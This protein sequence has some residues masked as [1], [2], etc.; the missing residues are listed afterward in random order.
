MT[1][2]ATVPNRAYFRERLFFG[3]AENDLSKKFA[4][5]SI[6]QEADQ[7]SISSMWRGLLGSRAIE[8][9]NKYR[10]ENRIDN[11]SR[12]ISST[13]LLEALRFIELLP[14]NI[15]EPE[16]TADPS[17]DLSFD[18]IIDKN[19]IFSALIS[20]RSITYAGILGKGNKKYGEEQFINALPKTIESVIETYFFKD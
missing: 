4:I 17:G 3:T 16:L 20:E 8:L 10:S 2:C 11:D 19:L 5:N 7:A 18:W 1:I 13:S 9:F 12:P 6:N 14:D 15:I